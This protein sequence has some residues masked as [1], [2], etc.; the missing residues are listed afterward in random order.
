M[1]AMRNYIMVLAVCNLLQKEIWKM[2]KLFTCLIGVLLLLVTAGSSSAAHIEIVPNQPPGTVLN[3]GDPFSVQIQLFADG[4]E[5]LT[6]YAFDVCFDSTEL[7]YVGAAEAWPQA[8]FEGTTTMFLDVA[9]L[10]YVAPDTVMYFDG[11]PYPYGSEGKALSP[12]TP[13][14]F[15]TID[16]T[17][18]TP[19]KDGAND[20]EVCYGLGADGFRINDVFVKLDTNGPDVAPVPIPAAAWLLGSGLL[21]LIGV[22]RYRTS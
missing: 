19:V 1:V 18:V 17:V 14:V 5:I 21:G 11:F 10:S 3:P 16:F 7:E 8:P 9:P 20:V 22:R 13:I 4:S 6:I 12:T 15:G 2:K